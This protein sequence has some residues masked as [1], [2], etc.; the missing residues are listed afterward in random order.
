MGYIEEQNAYEGFTVDL[1]S[2]EARDAEPCRILGA[3]VENQG[4]VRFTLLSAE[5]HFASA[6]AHQMIRV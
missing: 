6:C 5:H 1:G 2:N 3:K 4:A